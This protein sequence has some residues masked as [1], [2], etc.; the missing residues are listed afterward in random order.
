MK[1]SLENMK[2]VL[3]KIQYENEFWNICGELNV[4][5]RFLCLQLGYKM[6]CCVLCEWDS[7]VINYLYIQTQLPKRYLLISRDKCS[8]YSTNQP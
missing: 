3:E 2:L 1:E 6:F 8:N 4:T 5:A 7:R